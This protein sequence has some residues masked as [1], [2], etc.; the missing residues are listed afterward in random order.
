MTDNPRPRRLRLSRA[1][2]WRMPEG[3][4]KVDRSSGFGNPFPIIRGTS[5][6]GGVTSPIWQIGSW[7]GPAMWFRDIE[8][9]ARALSVKAF[10]AWIEH[11]AQQT[12]RQ[13]AGI[14]LR[15]KNLACWCRLCARHAAGKPFGEDCPDCAPCHADVLGAIANGLICEEVRP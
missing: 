7:N 11:P 12:L 8:A 15:G 14:A 3:T 6:S 2:G 1:K 10:R 9:D 13:R 4:V 5:T